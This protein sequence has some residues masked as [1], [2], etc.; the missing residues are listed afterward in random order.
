MRNLR[1]FEYF[2]NP[3][4]KRLN[5]EQVELK[6]KVKGFRQIDCKGNMRDSS[7]LPLCFGRVKFSNLKCQE[8]I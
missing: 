8:D 3:D 7:C 2:C 4:L 5:I 1:K 6:K